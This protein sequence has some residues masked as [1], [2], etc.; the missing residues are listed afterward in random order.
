[1]YVMSADGSS[2]TRLTDTPEGNSFHPPC[3]R[4]TYNS[5]KV[6]FTASLGEEPDIDVELA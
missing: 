2:R 6:R 5:V 3:D 4:Q 1:M